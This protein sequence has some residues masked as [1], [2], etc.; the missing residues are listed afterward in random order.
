MKTD[1]VP[2]VAERGRNSLGIH[3]DLDALRLVETGHGKILAW[4]KVPY[5][6]GIRP[7]MPGFADFLKQSVG[8]L[9][10]SRHVPIWASASLPSLQ[11]RFLSLPKVRPRQ[12][13]N[14]AYWTFRK[15]IPFDAAQVVFDYDV[16]GESTAGGSARKLD[17][18]ACTV[19]HADIKTI[20]SVFEE[21]QLDLEG[22]LLPSFAMR[23]VVRLVG[24]TST[25]T[26]LA[27]H[28]GDDASSIMFMRGRC[29]VSHRVFKTGMN[30][31]IDVLRDRHPEWSPVVAAGKMSE[32][33]GDPVPVLAPGEMDESEN[34]RIRSTVYAAY[35]R[36]IQQVERTISAYLT[37]RGDE[38][39]STIYVA[40]VLADY[41]ALVNELGSKL[42][43]NTR[44]LNAFA[45]HL[46]LEKG[47]ASMS[48]GEAGAMAIATGASLSD[49]A[50]T[51]NLLHTYVKREH[52]MRLNRTRRAVTAL[53][54][55]AL[56]VLFALH[57]VIH[58]FN[59]GLRE[60]LSLVR[61][62]IER[63]APYPDRAMILDLTTKAA[64][65]SSRLK[66]MAERCHMLASLNQLAAGTSPDIR[67]QSI[68]IEQDDVLATGRDS[69]RKV[70]ASPG[71]VTTG[72]GG[73]HAHMKGIV[74]GDPGLQESKLAQYILQVEQTDM[75]SRALLTGTEASRDAGAP[76][77]RFGADIQMEGLADAPVAGPEVATAKEVRP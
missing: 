46:M 38:T 63:F 69:R 55:A 64:I 11:V 43:L 51:P 27:L 74:S 2:A 72:S 42:G 48:P 7:G 22:L 25:E 30:V 37:G 70:A 14:L 49:P 60:E 62:Q 8:D 17:I 13:S 10:V 6:S 20:T 29:V 54:M 33:L 68:V 15:E 1:V 31:M 16:E 18:T 4:K 9:P 41:S 58:F 67:L 12:V 73:I 28:V 24:A 53:G 75:F 57:G 66:S 59:R 52:E 61:S 32:A 56:L 36:L 21:A 5:P 39:I 45:D 77:L 47:V 44:P 3:L 23:N 34:G 40:G 71:I 50:Q 19:A 76:V 26:V 35:A 65:R